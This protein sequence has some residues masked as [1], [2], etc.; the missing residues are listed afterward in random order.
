VGKIYSEK[1]NLMGEEKKKSNPKKQ[2]ISENLRY[3]KNADFLSPL[4]FVFLRFDLIFAA[5]AFS[6]AFCESFACC[7]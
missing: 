3:I 6:F 5:R 1:I 4:Y 7:K 2:H